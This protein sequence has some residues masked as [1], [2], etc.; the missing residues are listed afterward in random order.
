MKLSKDSI[1]W[2][3]THLNKEN[4]TDIFPKAYEIE[5]ITEMKDLCV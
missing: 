3:I 4:D 5:V 2:A 1:E